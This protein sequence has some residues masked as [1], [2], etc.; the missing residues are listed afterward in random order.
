[1]CRY[2]I[3]AIELDDTEH[4]DAEISL[5]QFAVRGIDTRQ[6]EALPADC[7]DIQRYVRHSVGQSSKIVDHDI[8]PV[9][10]PNVHHA[11][12]IID[13]TVVGQY[14]GRRRPIAVPGAGKEAVICS[15]RRILQPPRLWLQFLEARERGVEVCLVENL[16]AA[17]Q[18]AFDRKDVRHA[19]LAVETLL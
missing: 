11:A 19:P 16:A 2:L 3:V 14:L 15:G 6:G 7:N 13:K 9:P 5:L 12:A 1:V 8:A 18:V 17:D 10:N 4:F